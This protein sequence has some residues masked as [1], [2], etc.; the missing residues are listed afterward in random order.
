IAVYSEP[1][2]GTSFKI[3]FPSA[4]RPGRATGSLS[5]I[6]VAPRGTETVLLVEDEDSVRALTA[7]VLI[8]CGYR[9]LS[10]ANGN[11]ALRISSATNDPIHL[12]VT[13]V[14]MP[15]LGGRQLVEQLQTAHSEAKVL[16]LSGYTDDAVVRHGILHEDV[17]FLQKPYSPIGLAFKVRE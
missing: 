7:H 13:D 16:Y 1:G 12:V 15:E 14:V 4:D 11:E 5:T 9:V 8:D 10:A 2:I 3:F 6:K 17:Q